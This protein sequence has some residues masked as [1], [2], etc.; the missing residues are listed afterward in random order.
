MERGSLSNCSKDAFLSSEEL[1]N[2]FETYTSRSTDNDPSGPLFGTAVEY[3]WYL[4]HRRSIPEASRTEIVLCHVAS[5]IHGLDKDV[6]LVRIDGPDMRNPS[7]MMNITGQS[8]A[9]PKDLTC[10]Y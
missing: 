2:E 9:G 10:D 8:K 3:L 5:P 7:I 4:I 6:G 1:P